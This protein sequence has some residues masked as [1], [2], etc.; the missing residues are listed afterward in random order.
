[1]RGPS[2]AI[3]DY[4]NHLQILDF[5]S[6]VGP[7]NITYA[8]RY[9]KNDRPI[10]P[11]DLWIEIKGKAKNLEVALVAFAN[12]GLSMFPI[13]TLS[14]NAV[15]KTPDIELGFDNT[16]DITERDYFQNFIPP[17][18]EEIHIRRKIKI[19]ATVSLMKAIATHTDSERLRRAANQYMLALESWRLGQETLTLA[20]LW[21]AVEALTK[22]KLRTERLAHGL[23]DIELANKMMLNLNN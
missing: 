14:A 12:A 16:P 8:T 1:M 2:S 5:H 15:T 17:E 6:V 11:G 21:M 18:T 13:L 9:L 19:K 10:L 4:G 23:T 7:V 20:H 3:F 22:A